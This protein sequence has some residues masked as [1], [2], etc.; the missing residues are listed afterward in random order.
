M[1]GHRRLSILDLSA[2]GRQPMTFKDGL[3]W[4]V[5]NG[6]VYNYRELR[7]TLREQGY[8]FKSSSDTEVILAAYGFWG[9][10]C[11]HHFNGMWSFCIYDVRNHAIFC[12]RDR[13]GVKPFYFAIEG[14]RFGFASEIK[15]L[16]CA[17]FGTGRASRSG[18]SQF[19]LYGEANEERETMFEGI[20]QLLPSESLRWKIAD[21]VGGIKISRYYQPA[22]NRSMRPDGKLSEYRDRFRAYLREAVELRLRSDVP[23]GTCLS[24]GLDSSSIVLTANRLLRSNGNGAVKQKTF[25]SCFED[26]AYDEWNFA[27]SVVSG[28]GVQAC[29]VFPL[30]ERLWEELPNLS[31]HQDEPF[32]STS[33]YAQWNVMRLAK[34]NGVKVLLDGQ[35]ADEVM[36]GYHSLVLDYL[37]GVFRELPVA[38]AMR[39]VRAMQKTGILNAA[40]RSRTGSPLDLAVRAARRLLNLHSLRPPSLG[41]VVTRADLVPRKH[42]SNRFQ[43]ML[44]QSIFGSL[45]ALLR[46]EDRNSMAFSVEARTPYLDYRIVELFL[47]MPG[48]YKLRDGWTKPFIREAMDGTMAEDVRF[49]VDK[50]GFVT[51]EAEWVQRNLSRIRSVLLSKDAP[52]EAWIDPSH[53]ESWLAARESAAENDPSVWRLIS[54]HFWMKAFCL[55]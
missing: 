3:L 47:A 4:I 11:L 29:R 45:Q 31:W 13:F 38:E 19:L 9:E 15:Q 25:T 1:L 27:S 5:F 6:E 12:S 48:A 35:G 18:V 40:V 42:C 37:I 41:G 52:L 46:Y 8:E 26:A 55:S 7:E 34:E 36:A 20:Q 53:L 33:I 32:G 10:D 24:G 14:E 39:T 17:G 50:K 16:R 30:M 28:L 21:G 2:C 54:T 44:Y 49:R 51:P 43:E 23:V 22:A